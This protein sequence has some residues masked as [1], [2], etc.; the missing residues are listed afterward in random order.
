MF[1]DAS[2]IVAILGREPGH[3]AAG[4]RRRAS[5][6]TRA[7]FRHDAGATVVIVDESARGGAGDDEAQPVALS[8]PVD[9]LGERPLRVRAPAEH[10]PAAVEPMGRRIDRLEAGQRGGRKAAAL[11][12]GSVRTS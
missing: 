7:E 3:E 6:D 12:V 2:A 1:V 4:R 11:F 9:R 10:G 8:R 5:A